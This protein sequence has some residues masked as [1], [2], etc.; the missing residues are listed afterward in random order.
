MSDINYLHNEGE[1]LLVKAQTELLAEHFH[2][3]DHETTSSIS[4][5]PMRPTLNATCRDHV[6]QHTNNKEQIIRKE[7]KNALKNVPRHTVYTQLNKDSNQLIGPPPND[8]RTRTNVA[9]NCTYPT[10]ATEN[11]RLSPAKLLLE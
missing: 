5:R 10:S 2:S 7:Y 11:W 6:K 8:S 4:F 3:V 1:K 9:T